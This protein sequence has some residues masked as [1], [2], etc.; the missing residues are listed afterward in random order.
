MSLMVR[1]ELPK[2][3]PLRDIGPTAKQ[4]AKELWKPDA[5][6]MVFSSLCDDNNSSIKSLLQPY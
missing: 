3:D 2:A 1:K 5:E 4:G 6:A